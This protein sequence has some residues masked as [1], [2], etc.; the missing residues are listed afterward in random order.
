MQ[1]FGG[2]LKKTLAVPTSKLMVLRYSVD[3]QLVQ[4]GIPLLILSGCP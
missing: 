4:S 1:T 2:S 3:N